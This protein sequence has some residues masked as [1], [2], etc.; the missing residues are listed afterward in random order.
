MSEDIHEPLNIA[1]APLLRR[2]AIVSVAEGALAGL[3]IEHI[4]QGGIFQLMARPGS[5][6]E[7]EVLAVMQEAVG[8]SKGWELRVFGPGQWFLLCEAIDIA[9]LL[10]QKFGAGVSVVDQSH[11]RCRIR[12]SG[13]AVLELLPKGTGV[14]LD[15]R[16]FPIGRS[17]A[18]LF[19]HHGVV[20]TRNGLENFEV[21]V[22]RSLAESLID[23][24]RLLAA[25][26]G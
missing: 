23:E 21:L 26:T 22:L 10:Q 3:S 9:D 5:V 15:I 20:L 18:T 19:G 6:G 25:G 17:A 7:A 13:P 2:H 1:H 14:D 11:G 8:S 16:A 24:F 4:A 12:I